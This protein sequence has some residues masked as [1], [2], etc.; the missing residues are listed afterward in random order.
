MSLKKQAISGMFWTFLQQFSTQGISFVVSIVLA[1]LLLPSE[2][3]LIAMIGVFVGLGTA[4]INSGLTQSLIR[5]IEPD[6]E[7]F[8]TVFFFNLAGS[9][10]IYIII[11]VC[12]PYIA[13]FYHQG[14]LTMIVR[15]YCI[16][17]IINAFS[18]IQTT[19]LT[20]NMDFKTQ[21]KVSVPSLII[22]SIV[23]IAMAYTGFGVWSLVW[24][25]IVQALAATIQLWYWSKWSPSWVF[26]MQKFK[27]HFHY[28][29]K[30]MLSGLLGI[31]FSNAYTIIIGKFFVPAQVGFYNRADTLQQLPVINISSMLNK[32]TFPL[33]ATIQEDN[34]RLKSVYKRI[35]QMVIFLVA[36]ILI[37]MGVLAEPLFR[38]LFTDKWLPSVP[39]FQILCA[40]GILFPIHSYNLTILKVKGRSDLFLKLEI[41][42]KILTIIIILISFQFGILGLLYGSVVTS[43]LCFFI[44]THY[45]GKFLDYTAWAQAKDLMPII[46][47]ALLSGV[48]TFFVDYFLCSQHL[49]DIVRLLAGGIAGGIIFVGISFLY[50]IESLFEIK[51]IVL[52]K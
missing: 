39:Y 51:K 16:T 18:A 30:L 27:Y 33:F 8:S 6:Q 38:F 2:F 7:D 10:I 4:L 41:I 24:S 17:F 5:S 36:P 40:N 43:I 37:L 14:L 19:R 26:N 50:K 20:K 23:G 25:A 34:F 42:K 22:A 46:F 45:S 9:I 49:P 15:V 1:R 29:V 52:S 13:D 12:A 31:T 35:M 11:F 32:V 28:G 48:G 21:M 44:N 47:L 3:G